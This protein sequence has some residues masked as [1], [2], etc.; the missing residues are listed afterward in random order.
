MH[1][2]LCSCDSPLEIIVESLLACRRLDTAAN[3]SHFAL[4]LINSVQLTRLNTAWWS[5]EQHKRQHH[6]ELP[7][8][9]LPHLILRNR[10]LQSKLQ[11]IPERPL[12]NLGTFFMREALCSKMRQRFKRSNSPT[13]LVLL[14]LL[15]A[16]KPLPHLPLRA[17]YP[18]TSFRMVSV[19]DV[20]SLKN[21]LASPST[22]SAR[23]SDPLSS[24]A[25]FTTS[26]TTL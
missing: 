2:D 5:M 23:M 17:L 4:A 15:G 13:L 18:P 19:S 26:T 16:P 20:F 14:P 24:L 21:G 3:S 25:M 12:K 9:T 8:S 6:E 7:P 22:D 10:F 1:K 11:C